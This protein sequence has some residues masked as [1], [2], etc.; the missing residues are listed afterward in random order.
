MLWVFPK[1]FVHRVWCTTVSGPPKTLCTHVSGV[2]KLLTPRKKN[3][4]MPKIEHPKT[5]TNVESTSFRNSTQT[6][7]N[8]QSGKL[9]K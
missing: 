6:L 5:K 1:P 8:N 7:K 9:D 2:L 3:A 4:K